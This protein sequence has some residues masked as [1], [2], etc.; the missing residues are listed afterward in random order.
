M[1]RL[2]ENH[3]IMG[4]WNR[5][6]GS[7]NWL[8]FGFKTGSQELLYDRY[9]R[10][11]IQKIW[12]NDI[13]PCRLYLRHWYFF[14]LLFLF[15]KNQWKKKKNVWVFQCFSGEKSGRGGKWQFPGQYIPRRQK[16]EHPEVFIFYWCWNNGRRTDRSSQGSLWWLAKRQQNI[17]FFSYFFDKFSYDDKFHR[18]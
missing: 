3:F 18:K 4:Y 17:H 10:H 5:N 16:H 9:G 2:E 14:F 11:N 12:R 8:V 1:Q 13:L 7:W 15:K 6:I